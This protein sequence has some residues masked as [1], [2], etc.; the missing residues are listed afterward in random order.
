MELNELS[1]NIELERDANNKPVGIKYAFHGTDY[2]VHMALLSAVAIQL[3]KTI[4]VPEKH[5]A[6]MESINMI[7]NELL[8][9]D[10]MQEVQKNIMEGSNE[11]H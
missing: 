9:S 1:V 6:I 4:Y 5:N 10:T 2:H 7:L 3:K 11:I 8:S